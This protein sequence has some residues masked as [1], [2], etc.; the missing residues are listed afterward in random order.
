MISLKN[1]KQNIIDKNLNLL[2]LMNGAK[3]QK[4]LAL[5]NGANT[6][7]KGANTLAK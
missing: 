4:L 2:A 3:T 5:K 1:P 6:P 7:V